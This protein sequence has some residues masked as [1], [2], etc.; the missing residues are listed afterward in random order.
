[1]PTDLRQLTTR[2]A[3]LKPLA[4]AVRVVAYR[5]CTPQYATEPDLLS[6]DGS[7][8]VGARWNPP[9]IAA[10]YFSLSPEA[11]LAETLAYF[12]YYG[13]PIAQ[14][15]PRVFVALT[16]R[17]SAVLDLTNGRVRRRLQISETSML[18]SDWR[19]IASTGAVPLT[20]L[21][22]HAA[23]AAGW[24]GLRVRSAAHPDGVNLVVFPT[25]VHAG[26][27]LELNRDAMS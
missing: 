20:Q 26:S 16:I 7:R 3:R 11:A 17:L 24:E 10:V 6:G 2:F 4:E 1:M 22:G 21:V 8:K 23:Y 14:A 15:M 12:R 13:F 18:K 27:A 19:K 25:N 5:S 9:G